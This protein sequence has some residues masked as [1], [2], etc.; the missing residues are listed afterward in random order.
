MEKKKAAHPCPGFMGWQLKHWRGQCGMTQ[1]Q[2]AER[3]GIKYRH[4]QDIEAGNVDIKL[5]TLGAL[6]TALEL[7][8]HQL[9]TPVEENRSRMCLECRYMLDQLNNQR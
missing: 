4:L 1:K 2:L 3:S 9:L 6:A 7:T 5:R 8:P